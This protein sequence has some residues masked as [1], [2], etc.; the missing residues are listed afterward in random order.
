MMDAVKEWQ[1]QLEEIVP[2]LAGASV[3]VQQSAI[4]KIEKS[5]GPQQATELK[6]WLQLAKE[7]NARA[8][9]V[10]A[11]LPP[12][13]K[14]E[15]QIVRRESGGDRIRARGAQIT[16]EIEAELNGQTEPKVEPKPKP[17]E[18][19]EKIVDAMVKRGVEF[20][21]SD[22]AGAGELPPPT[23][24]GRD[25]M[26]EELAGLKNTDAFEY[27]KKAKDAAKRLGVNQST[28]EK[29]VKLEL[30]RRP[31]EVTERSQAARVA[32]LCRGK[33][34]SLWRDE[35]KQG[36]AS[37]KVDGHWEH[38]R[39][40]SRG[41]S[42]WIKAEYG[43]KY[44]VKHGDHW[45]EQVVGAQALRDGV[46]QI[47]A[48][49]SRS[50]LEFKPALRVGGGKGEIW[51][52]LGT[53]E[54]NAI[55][56][57]AEGWR[58]VPHAGVP[59]V[60]T[61]NI[62]PLPIPVRGGNI[63]EL[64][65][66]LNVRPDDFA[67]VVGWLLQVLNPVG[68]YPVLSCEGASENGKTTVSRMIL[69]T[70]DPNPVGLRSASNE[71]AFYIGAKNNHAV[72]FDNVSRMYE[73]MADAI[74]K[75]STGTA[76]GA[77]KLYTDD[78]ESAFYAERPIL[79]NGIPP[80][81]TERSDLASRTIRLYIP[82]IPMEKRR[83]LKV[84]WTEFEEMWP[85]LLGA[86]CDGLVGALRNADTITID[87]PARLADFEV[88][89]EAGTRAMGFPEWTFVAR[90]RQNRMGSMR[91]SA[92]ADQVGRAV[93]KFLAKQPDGYM[94][95]MTDLLE[96]LNRYKDNEK[97][98]KW[99]TDAT[100]LSGSLRRLVRPLAGKG[101]E[102]EVEVDLRPDGP[103]NGV[104]LEWQE[105]FAPLAAKPQFVRRV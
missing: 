51:I 59:F 93:Q 13:P 12:E 67:L 27:E 7:I 92:D 104:I 1:A 17:E 38:Y 73:D 63:Q 56:A 21:D 57:T 49:A 5:Y 83:G 18:G 11:K 34:V 103:Q 66:V 47:E 98:R 72:G 70:V 22:K 26:I 32:Q 86:L 30:A 76:V 87:E 9:E 99:P 52:D 29:Q 102:V 75:I 80:D 81:L 74:C 20:H 84:L 42:K 8:A 46:A 64:Q 100:R 61:G 14:P 91:S 105:G 55:H 36:Y 31:K 60:R 43:T 41:F 23:I 19:V 16:A 85:R 95:S 89:A 50:E 101:I 54:C 88:W 44:R 71:N 65:S 25:R 10:S 6:N 78:E 69:Q 53:P 4:G 62:R 2:K 79:I 90:Y 39:I 15:P 97:D 37:V 24:Q 35:F 28:I 68:P 33:D 82:P 40:E 94:G 77:R 48:W 45:E 58:I 3:E 96:K